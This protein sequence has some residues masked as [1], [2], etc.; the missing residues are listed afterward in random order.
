MTVRLCSSEA[1]HRFHKA[2]AAGSNP[3]TGTTKMNPAKD[4]YFMRLAIAEA[5]K[6]KGPKRFGAVIVRNG[7]VIAKAH[8]TTYET[9]EPIT[10]A[11]SNA[12]TSASRK[13]KSRKLKD[14]TIYETGESCLLCAAAMLKTEISRIVV[15]FDHRDYNQL[16]GRKKLNPWSR[17]LKD[18]IPKGIPITMGV[19]RKECME[20]MFNPKCLRLK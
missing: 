6:A 13:L 9:N 14:C 3:A 5:K 1:E 8:N 12:I 7:K 20:M 16:D 4:R 19:L 10:C 18:I 17:H 15:G 11:E 2:R